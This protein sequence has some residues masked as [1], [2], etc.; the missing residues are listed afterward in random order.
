MSWVSV[1]QVESYE[2]KDP[3]ETPAAPE[4]SGGA[5]GLFGNVFGGKKG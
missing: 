4:P 2:R 3:P 5:R 1:S